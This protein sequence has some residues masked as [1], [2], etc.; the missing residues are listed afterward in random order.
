MESEK[1]L[2]I[3]KKY[4]RNK[5]EIVVS[6]LFG[7]YA[8]NQSNSLSDIDIALLLNKKIEKE[9]ELIYKAKL[10]A[11][12]MSVLKTNLVDIVCLNSA[13]PLLAHRVI[14]DGIIIDSKDEKAR[15]FFETLSLNQYIDTKPLREIQN[16]YFRQRALA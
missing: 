2:N 7:S 5:P 6:Y 13:P 1:I 3:L 12:L 14:R 8:R 9:G 16:L 11:D 4:F 15:I 10:I